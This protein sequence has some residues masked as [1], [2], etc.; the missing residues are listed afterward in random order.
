MINWR[1]KDELAE[2]D[3]QTRLS[4]I[5]HIEIIFCRELRNRTA[6]PAKG[7]LLFIEVSNGSC[8]C[9]RERFYA[10]RDLKEVNEELIH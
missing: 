2:S 4:R 9:V 7:A 5:Q 10:L 8:T 6:H 1:W 3:P